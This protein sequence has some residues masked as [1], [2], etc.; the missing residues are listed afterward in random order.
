MNRR[1]LNPLVAQRVGR[2]VASLGA[3]GLKPRASLGTA[4]RQSVPSFDICTFVTDEAQ[5]AAMRTSFDAAGFVPPLA[6]F[7]EL[8]DRRTPDG[9]DPYAFIAS[10]SSHAERPYVVLAHQDVRLDQGVGVDDLL[11]VLQELDEIDPHWVVAGNAGG[12]HD[13]GGVRRLRDPWSDAE[14]DRELPIRV[15][16]LDENFLVFNPA[17]DPRVSP[18]LDGFHFYATDVC[19]NALLD[20]GSAYVI[21]FAL[22]HLSSGRRGHEYEALRDRFAEAW[23][24]R[25]LFAIVRTPTELFYFSRWRIIRR[26]LGSQRV[27]VWV[28]AWG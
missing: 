7:V 27:R 23:N 12:L 1:R 22:T 6:R 2:L 20:G 19:L 3:R 16:S 10:L 26:V 4:V 17:H 28:R 24:R 9:S 11:Q 15:V 13:Q 5:Y 25:F 18:G 21:D 14:T 8:R